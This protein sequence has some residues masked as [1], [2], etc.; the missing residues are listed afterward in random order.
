MFRVRT[1]R[2]LMA[3]S[4][5]RRRLSTT[6]LAIFAGVALLLAAVGVYGTMS[7]SVAQRSHEMGIRM[8]LGARRREVVRL[9]LGQGVGLT[10]A[11]LAVGAAGSLLLTRL[12]SSL[13]FGVGA[14]DPVTFAAVAALLLL[15]ATA[16]NVVPAYRATTV[17]PVSSLR[18]E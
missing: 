8:A 7:Y 1:M 11:G 15:V 14:H 18:Q 13:L 12:I 17:D 3:E 6:L 2:E 5:A 16:A 9:V 4:V 10:G